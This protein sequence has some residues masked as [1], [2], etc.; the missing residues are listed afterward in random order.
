MPVSFEIGAVAGG[1]SMKRILIADDHVIVRE[2]LKGLLG[3]ASGLAVAG[4]AA[5]GDDVLRLVHEQ[6]WDMLVTDISMPGCNGI[7]L[8]KQVKR[9]R[10]ALPVLVV[11]M[12]RERQYAV[13][14]IRAGASGYIN[15]G[16]A[17]EEL[18]LAIGNV[19]SGGI[20]VTPAVVEAL[21]AG[22]GRVGGQVPHERLSKRE[23]QVASLLARGESQSEIAATLGLSAKTV[24]TH[25]ANILRKMQLSSEAELIRYSIENNLWDSAED[26]TM[27]KP[28]LAAPQVGYN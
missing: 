27:L 6:D 23:V 12:H 14:A 20:H 4:E 24:S 18:I 2:G 28:R 13:M 9:A 11:S 5:N 7:D 15:K 22:V 19:C 25:K 16:S 8:I 3:Q 26:G 1:A 10:P 21:F 17:G